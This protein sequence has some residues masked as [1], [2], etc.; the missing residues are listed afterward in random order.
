[1]KEGPFFL[2]LESSILPVRTLFF[3]VIEMSIESFWH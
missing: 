2:I 1:M 3:F